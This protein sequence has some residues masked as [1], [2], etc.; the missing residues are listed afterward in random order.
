M[1][2]ERRATIFLVRGRFNRGDLECHLHHFDT[3]ELYSTPDEQT[4]TVAPA[5][6]HVLLASRH[7]PE[8]TAGGPSRRI[9][10]K[11]SRN[12][13]RGTATSAIWKTTDRA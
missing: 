12:T 8:A 2:L 7:H 6:F 5:I 3:S 9:L 10:A 13:S 11:I 4:V 1:G